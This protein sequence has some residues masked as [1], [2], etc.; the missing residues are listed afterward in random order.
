MHIFVSPLLEY[1]SKANAEAKTQEV[2]DSLTQHT[3]TG[4]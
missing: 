3:A 4:M 1:L 2:R